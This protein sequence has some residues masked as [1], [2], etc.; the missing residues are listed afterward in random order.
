MF[1]RR[2]INLPK[3]FSLA[4]VCVFAM[5]WTSNAAA[6]T[7]SLISGN[8]SIGSPDP[9]VT[10]TDS[11]TGVTTNATIVPPYSDSGGYWIDP[12][13]GSQWVSVNAGSH[14]CNGTYQAT[15]ML[16]A[17]AISPSLSVTELADNSTN[18][19]LNGNQPFITGNVPGQCE[20][21]Q[22][23]PPVTGTTTSGLVPGVNTLTFNVDNCLA[24]YGVNPTGLDFVA[25]VTFSG[26]GPAP[27]PPAPP[28]PAPPP[29]APPPP[30]HSSQARWCTVLKGKAHATINGPPT[31]P[32]LSVCQ[33]TT[34]IWNGTSVKNVSLKPTCHGNDTMDLH[35]VWGRAKTSTGWAPMSGQLVN[36][37]VIDVRD[38]LR[39]RYTCVTERTLMKPDGQWSKSSWVTDWSRDPNCPLPRIW[40]QPQYTTW[41]GCQN[42]TDQIH[43][44]G[45]KLCQQ[46]RDE[47]DG[48]SVRNVWLHQ[49]YCVTPVRSGFCSPL[50]PERW[51]TY[52]QNGYPAI[53]GY[54]THYAVARAE[55]AQYWGLQAYE[56]LV[57]PICVD[58][59]LNRDAQNHHWVTGRSYKLG[60]LPFVRC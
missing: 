38:E 34:N 54:M 17:I 44:L 41:T 46:A 49:P 59:N 31:Q 19:S 27:P 14:G 29:P 7:I 40:S 23:G 57:L 26:S 10:V 18:V 32:Q 30:W 20:V 12:I 52:Y 2:P 3:C 25:T 9:N 6:A 47:W 13:S 51:D 4:V 24:G 56:H 21:A 39:Q 60:L 16:P 53:G 33:E 36:Y 22:D 55:E 5:M 48:V 43:F 35:C 15:F 11:C 1:F 45:N 50:D 8:G 58:L 28:P 42:F 37:Q